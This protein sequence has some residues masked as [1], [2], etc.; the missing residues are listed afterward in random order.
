M[1]ESASSPQSNGQKTR[2]RR[3]YEKAE[4][5]THQ[6]EYAIRL[7]GRDVK[8]PARNPLQCPTLALADLVA[9]EWNAQGDH[10]DPE[11]MVITGFC[12]AAI[13]RVEHNRDAHVQQIVGFA[14]TDTLSYR[15]DVGSPLFNLQQERWEPLLQRLE[16][17]HDVA[18]LRVSGIMPQPQSKPV[19]ELA[20]AVC[21]DQSNFA[22]TAFSQLV[23]LLG[24]FAFALM[25]IENDIDADQAWSAAFMET[26][27]QAEQW[28]EDAQ[29]KALQ[30]DR[31]ARFDAAWAMWC[32]LLES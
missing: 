16:A 31:R 15:D 11:T 8:T 25:L 19:L 29:A 18:W 20:R 26:D 21:K 1:A 3:F 23:E 24:S 12:N 10:L 4:V 14:D 5:Q 7:D 17:R 9:G 2:I 32:A 30:I 28:G 22:L 13:D 6:G 27:W